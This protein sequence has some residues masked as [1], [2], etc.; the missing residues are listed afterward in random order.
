M[1]DN[2]FW[3]HILLLASRHERNDSPFAANLISFPVGFAS[4]LISKGSGSV[5]YQIFNFISK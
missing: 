3:F 2:L 4:V 5:R 1:V